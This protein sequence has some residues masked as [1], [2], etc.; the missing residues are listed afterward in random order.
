ME[1][2][3]NTHALISLLGMKDKHLNVIQN[4]SC[5]SSPLPFTVLCA[6]FVR[7]VSFGRGYK[8]AFLD[9]RGVLQIT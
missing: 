9:A 3:D 4:E 1:M 2:I 6:E 8:F 7:C 5:S